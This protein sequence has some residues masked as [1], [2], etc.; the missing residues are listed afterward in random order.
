[1][2]KT[3]NVVKRRY[4][5]K[6]YKKLSIEM[7]PEFYNM[8]DNYCKETGESKT[9]FIC[10]MIKEHAQINMKNE[11]QELTNEIKKAL[12]CEKIA[13]NTYIKEIEEK[14]SSKDF[15]TYTIQEAGQ[16]VVCDKKIVAGDAEITHYYW[17]NHE[18]TKDEI[19][20]AEWLADIYNEVGVDQVLGLDW[21]ANQL[22]SLKELKA[23]LD[24]WE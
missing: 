16:W 24:N 8:L 4:N 6:A 14:I 1:M 9:G 18:P 10:R 2:G 17:F 7:K 13:A 12:G 19:E 20:F 23:K 22:K 21:E 3:S 15:G 5:N 11:I